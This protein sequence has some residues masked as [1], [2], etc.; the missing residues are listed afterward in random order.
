MAR[1]R[2]SWTEYRAYLRSDKWRR[3]R[4]AL[5]FSKNFTCERCGRYCRDGFEVHHKTYIRIY[6]E[7][8]SDLMLLCPD[9]H[10]ML[11]VQKRRER[12]WRECSRT[13]K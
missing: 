13:Q 1:T 10:R 5:G 4:L 8:L 12:K 9:C 6:K 3:K 7:L 11:E 2:F